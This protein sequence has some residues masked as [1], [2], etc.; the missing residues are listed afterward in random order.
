[1]KD[2][3]ID[4]D[5][6]KTRMGEYASRKEP[7]LFAVDFEMREAIF[8][9][10]PFQSTEVFF[11][12]RGL[13][14]KDKLLVSELPARGSAPGGDLKAYPESYEEYLRKF[15]VV[16]N[17]LLRGD[18]F[19][20]NLTIRTPI[21][22]SLELYEIFLKSDSLFQIYVPKRFVCF[23]PEIFVSVKDGIIRTYPMKGTINASIPDAERVIME[24]FKETAE[25]ATIVD[26]LRNDLS[27]VARDV[28]VTRYR[29]VDRLKTRQ[30]EILQISSEISGTLP[31]GWE[32]LL[33]EI[34]FGLLPP[35]S[36]SGAPKE[37]TL[38]IIRDAET[39]TRGFYTGIFGLYDGKDLDSAV[40]IRFI[41]EDTQGRR[42]FRSGGGITA[43]SR[44]EDEYLE[45]AEKIYLPFL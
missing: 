31:V 12:V 37:S 11:S 29:Y 3:Y 14:N 33:G 28:E 38:R 22:T 6:L 1:M 9:E 20:T 36:C 35:G 41:E 26:L 39:E 30:R 8:I 15:T 21:E 45:A 2:I 16:K 13:G 24:D 32:G 10:D 19:L 42:H 34:I 43:Y 40:L 23:S 5:L 27:I 18:S 25:H 7:F 17:G 44:P 4:P